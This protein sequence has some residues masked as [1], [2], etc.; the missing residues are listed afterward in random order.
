MR[1]KRNIKN[2]NSLAKMHKMIRKALSFSFL[3]LLLLAPVYGVMAAYAPNAIGIDNNE[4]DESL[5][6]LRKIIESNSEDKLAREPV[7]QEAWKSFFSGDYM[8]ALNG[9]KTLEASHSKNFGLLFAIGMISTV[10][11]D[12]AGGERYL[13]RAKSLQP[14]NPYILFYLGLHYKFAKNTKQ[15]N[16]YFIAA[17]KTDKDVDFF[18]GFAGLA[19]FETNEKLEF[20][21]LLK[22]GL[23]KQP[24]R[25]IL[26]HL[27]SMRIFSYD[28]KN[29]EAARRCADHLLRLYQGNLASAGDNAIVGM[30]LLLAGD[31]VSALKYFHV[32][33][34]QEPR[35]PQYYDLVID[36]AYSAEN[37]AK[38]ENTLLLI[39]CDGLIQH[40]IKARD[41]AAKNIDYCF[42][43]YANHESASESA[44]LVIKFF[45]YVNNHDLKLSY[46]AYMTVA[47]SY[48]DLNDLP[49]A[50]K[51][52]R[53]AKTVCT[54]HEQ[55]L[56]LDKIIAAVE[57]SL[58]K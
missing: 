40:N 2:D 46:L 19:L 44:S 53:L 55:S 37:E 58:E 9:L 49:N 15:A 38:R 25:K 57:K 33:M 50:L 39:G 11:G 34:L 51:L 48:R 20:T 10:T 18:W 24:D 35:K 47:G 30:L 12:L 56:K 45:K 31:Q 17:Y 16:Q 52:L 22:K 4:T 3:W 8:T 32:A 14:K 5:K 23:V 54:D 21:T 42:W 43:R 41:I 36:I 1:K 27:E 13:L 26:W 7:F 29:K 28:T 6:L